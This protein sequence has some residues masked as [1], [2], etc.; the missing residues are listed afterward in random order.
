MTAEEYITS[1]VDDQ[2]AWYSKKSSWNQ[3]VYKIAQTV[4]IVLAS[5]IPF[6]AGFASQMNWA[7]ILI[8]SF[9]VII[10]VIESLSKL[11]KLHE[12]W[13]QYRSTS[14]LLKYQKFLFTTQS[15]PYTTTDETVFNLFVR[16]VEQIVSSENNQW[17]ITNSLIESVP[18]KPK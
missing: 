3:R 6:F 18:N 1:R 9:G 11:Y 14:E 8:G 4:E 12:N 16:N 17:K 15:A 2:I 13:I 7:S 10:A 5:S